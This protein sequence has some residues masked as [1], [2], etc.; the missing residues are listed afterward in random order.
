M[1][2]TKEQML[3]WLWDKQIEADD[4][5]EGDEF[6]MVVAIRALIESSVPTVLVL[7][8][9]HAID[10]SAP[11]P[12]P[13]IKK[14]LRVGPSVEEAMETVK[15]ALDGLDPFFPLD[16]EAA[17]SVLKAALRPKVVSREWIRKRA[18]WAGCLGVTDVAGIL[19]ELGIEVEETP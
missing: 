8:D 15:L 16:V 11:S 6:N 9:E 19:R 2:I 18:D 13:T 5:M 14:D 17:F 3:K 1:N 10:L 4:L 7:D 12:A